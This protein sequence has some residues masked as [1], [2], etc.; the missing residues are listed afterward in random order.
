MLETEHEVILEP[1]DGP[2]NAAVLWLHGLGADGYDFVPMVPELHLPVDA[3]IRFVFP[4][5]TVRP[6]TINNGYAMRAW[7]D[8]RELTP[9][10]RDDEQGFAEARA[11]VESY[12]AHENAAGI[13]ARRIVVAGFSQGGAVALHAGLRHAARLA[14]IIAL[15]TYLP[16]RARFASELA[17]ANR[18]TPV[19]MCHG[20]EDAVVAAEFGEISRDALIQQGIPVEWHQYPMGHNLCA[21][22]V[23]DIAGWLRKHLS[24]D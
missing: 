10:G 1:A 4:H 2:A 13:S 11:R 22:E 12:I 8:I 9:A 14:G 5:A 21:P 24:L 16:L 3:R 18:D 19:L 23:R 7:Y 15:S 20:S 6:V 17:A